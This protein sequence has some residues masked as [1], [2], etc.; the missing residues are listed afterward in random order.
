MSYQKFDQINRNFFKFEVLVHKVFYDIL[1][2]SG[3]SGEEKDKNMRQ[4]NRNS[5]GNSNFEEDQDKAIAH[6]LCCN[7]RFHQILCELEEHNQT[8][9][10]I[11]NWVQLTMMH[12]M[13]F[14]QKLFASEMQFISTQIDAITK[15]KQQNEKVNLLAQDCIENE[16]HTMIR[17]FNLEIISLFFCFKYSERL[18]GHYNRSFEQA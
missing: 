2:H 18:H 10:V 13:R 1:P 9:D 14:L 17:Q 12:S 8:N 5:I 4:T 16:F 6:H 7:D 15:K 3:P 11:L